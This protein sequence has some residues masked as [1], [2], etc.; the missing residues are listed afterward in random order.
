MIDIS[1]MDD[2]WHLDFDDLNDVHGEPIHLRNYAVRS[3]RLSS[4]Q[5]L[6]R[7]VVDDRKSATTWIPWDHRPLVIHHMIVDMV[8]NYPSLVIDS[9]RAV[10][11]VH[12]NE[13]CPSIASR[14]AELAGISIAR[15]FTH[16]VRD[17][18]G[19]PKGCTHVTALLQ[20]MAPVA[21]QSTW[22]MKMAERRAEAAAEGFDVANE[23]RP[24]PSVAER[25]HGALTNLNTCHVFAEDGERVQLLRSGVLQ[26]MPLTVRR[27]YEELGIPIEGAPD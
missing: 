7:G 25:I 13:P 27:R 26:P 24:P 11:D 8:V 12:P 10:L 2:P 18:F 9:V 6:I 4:E 17:A 14:Y 15:G 3:Y 16:K 20:A 23:I 22:P 5:V 1:P 19:G 21:V